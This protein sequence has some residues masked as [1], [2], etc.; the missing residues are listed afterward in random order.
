MY[1]ISTEGHKIYTQRILLGFHSALLEKLLGGFGVGDLP[2]ISAPASSGCLVNLLKILISGVAISNNKTHLLEATKFCEVIGIKLTN[3]QIGSKKRKYDGGK[4]S[5]IAKTGTEVNFQENDVKRNIPNQS[6]LNVV[7]II[8]LSSV[9][10]EEVQEPE[11]Q[12]KSQ[13]IISETN[14]EINVSLKHPCSYCGKEFNSRQSLKRHL[15]LHSEDPTPFA[16]DHCDKKFDRKYRLHKHIKTT[17]DVSPGNNA[18]AITEEV[19]GD[20]EKLVPIP[21]ASEN[22]EMEIVTEEEL[23]SKVAEEIASSLEE[24]A[25]L[26]DT[27]DGDEAD[28]M[29]FNTSEATAEEEKGVEEE[30]SDASDTLSKDH[31]QLLSDRKKLLEELSTM[32]DLDF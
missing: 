9:V 2:G 3:C 7:N 22:I 23:A 27:V 19:L 31:E 11:E 20:P 25:Y 14:S 4:N 26:N 6:D 29:K 28:A 30:G 32:E 10:K 16:C 15:L 18:M 5:P 1:L 17:H 13:E 8:P 12:K 21:K 24:D